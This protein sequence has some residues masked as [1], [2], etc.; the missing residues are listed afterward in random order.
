MGIRTNSPAPIAMATLSLLALVACT[1]TNNNGSQTFTIGGAVSGLT[2]S[3]LV[4]QNNGAGNLPITANGAFTFPGSI[5]NGSSYLVTV[6]AE[7]TNPAE[8]CK[9]TD[10][11]GT[12]SAN[13]T[14]I[15]VTCTANTP[16]ITYTI[17]GTV[18]GLTGSGLVLQDNGANNLPVTANGAFV[19]TT[20]IASGSV[21]AVTVLTQPSNPAQSCTVTSGSGTA[22][23]NVTNV[24]VA[25]AK[26]D[27]NEWTWMGGSESVNQAGTYGT[28]GTPSANNAPGARVYPMAWTDAAGNFWLFGGYGA[29]STE[30]QGDL[31]DLWEYNDGQ[32]TWVNGSDQIEQQGTYGTKGLAAPGN[33][34]GARYQGVAWVDSFGNSWIFGGLGLDSTGT[35][36]D[37]NDLWKYSGGQW[38]WMSGS[39]KANQPGIAGEDQPGIYGTLGVPAPGNVPGARV[40]A[41]SW[42]DSSGNLWLFGGEGVDANGTLGLLNDLWK[43][44][45]GEWTWMSGSN[46]VN[47]YGVYGTKGTPAAGNAPGARTDAVTWTDAEGSLWLFGG[48][49]NDSNGVICSV[50]P[51]CN[52]NDLWKFNAGEW[53]WIG[54]SDVA[55]ESGIYGTQ[56]D[57]APGNVPGARWGAI[58]WTDSAGNFWL[59]G[60]FALDSRVGP[61]VYG[62]IDDLWEYSGGQW[63]WVDGP[64]TAGNAGSYGTLG[65][66][67][68][69]N[70]PTA[71]DSAVGWIDKSGNLWI[72]GGGDY[73]SI[74]GGGKFND[75]WE[76]Q[77]WGPGGP[78]NNPPPKTYT[79]SG[80][81]SGLSGT[82]VVLQDNSADNLTITTNGAFTFARA[83]DAGSLYSVTVLTQPAGPAQYCVVANGTGIA[84][85]DVSDV[86]VTCT[87]YTPGRD[88]WTWVSGADYVN[89]AGSY[90]TLGVASAS[91]VPG[92]RTNA[93]S[94]TDSSGN[95][96]LF[97]GNV[98][99][100]GNGLIGP[101]GQLYQIFFDLNDLWKFSAGEWTWMGGSGSATSTQPGIYG[102]QGAASSSNIP[103]ARHSAVTWTDAS[104]NFWLFGGVGIDATGTQ[105]DLNDLWEFS[106]GQWAWIAGSKVVNQPG[107]YGLQGT[108]ASGNNPGARDS[109]MSWTDASGNLWLLGGFGM[110]STGT[111]C[112]N[113]YN[114]ECEL[115]DLWKFSGGQWTWVS[116]SKIANQRGV[117]GTQ[118]TGSSSTYPGARQNASIAVDKSGNAWLS[119][120]FGLDST[121]FLGFL[122]DLWE[123]SGGQW[124]WVSGANTGNE[125]GDYGTQGT[126]AK[127]NFAGARAGAVSWVDASGNFWLFSGFGEDSL[128]KTGALNDLWK[129]SGGV[130]TW[131]DGSNLNSQTGTYGTKGTSAPGNIPSGR[132][133]SSTWKDASGDFWVF[134]GGT[135]GANLNDLWEYQP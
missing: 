2:G 63:T 94:W 102:T 86:Q 22:T 112:Y 15:Q 33:V 27:A 95:F 74:P 39:D 133:A 75:L 36:G 129:F 134:G 31:N 131:I 116:G 35:R 99:G 87:A 51:I 103:G 32:W 41:N 107:V 65:V 49:G 20:P 104:G 7:P 1:T 21:Y 113:T 110:D 6:L 108:A 30:E 24:Q 11:S 10:G 127:G 128:G 105:G 42:A 18:T 26:A 12:A 59:F 46:T 17:G 121:G 115:N 114:A 84:S 57:P 62:D 101:G 82:E 71:R 53:T 40:D 55:N 76:Y 29:A 77:G 88:V 66:A 61:Q 5:A 85:A 52:L 16:P 38:T 8:T 97:G 60:G 73:L 122:N 89:Q 81:V 69:T 91:N 47:A 3:G 44:S 124:K 118:G 50:A 117:Y 130:W 48:E 119:G 56:G 100:L 80:A 126:G 43:F 70:L 83:I 92:A 93:A 78:P 64:N 90:G 79:I 98:G 106:D 125:L 67:S 132:Y 25:C 4:L 58:S 13:V 109:A 23:S 54:G 135:G 120:G 72:L 9:V 96:W 37:L 14:N 111:A 28:Q 19:F 34:P 68:P 123:Y 45:A